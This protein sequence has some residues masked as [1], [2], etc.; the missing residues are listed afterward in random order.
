MRSKAEKKRKEK[1][2]EIGESAIYIVPQS[3]IKS[4]A[5]YIEAKISLIGLVW[6]EE[7]IALQ[8]GV[9]GVILM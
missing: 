6:W 1:R 5:L 2:V 7:G 3:T 8:Q 9:P 4:L